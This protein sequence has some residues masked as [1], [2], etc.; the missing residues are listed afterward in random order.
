MRA[1]PSSTSRARTTRYEIRDKLLARLRRLARFKN[2][3]III[4]L[5]PGL[6]CATMGRGSGKGKKGTPKNPATSTSMWEGFAGTTKGSFFSAPAWVDP[7]KK[8]GFTSQAPALVGNPNWATL[9]SGKFLF[10]SPNLV[11]LAVALADYLIF[12]YD[13]EASTTSTGCDH[14]T[15]ACSHSQRRPAGGQNLGG[16]LDRV[17]CGCEHFDRVQLLRYSRLVLSS[18]CICVALHV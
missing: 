8:P 15:Q 5:T 17:P 3:I 6:T 4:I 16:R 13:F 18:E 9:V 10:W 11:W 7:A 2:R 1:A 12:P 14:S